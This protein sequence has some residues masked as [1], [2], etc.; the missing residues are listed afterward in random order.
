E[1]ADEP[2]GDDAD[3]AGMKLA[4]GDHQGRR[5]L[6][7]IA[8]GLLAGAL[9]HDALERLPLNVLLL[10]VAGQLTGAVRVARCQ[11]LDHQASA[12]ETATCQASLN[13]TAAPD[14][15]PNG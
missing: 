6:H 8:L 15:M 13:A 12:A 3:D 9:E 2:A 1:Q 11:Q 4:A 5:L 7:R 14:N 10:Q